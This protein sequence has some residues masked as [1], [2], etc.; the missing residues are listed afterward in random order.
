MI[1]TEAWYRPD[2]SIR[3]IHTDASATFCNKLPLRDGAY[4]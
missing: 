1:K 2:G 3:N 4:V